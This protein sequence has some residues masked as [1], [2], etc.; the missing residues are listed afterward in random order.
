MPTQQQSKNVDA[1]FM[2]LDRKWVWGIMLCL[3]L[4]GCSTSTVSTTPVTPTSIQ[5]TTAVAQ[6]FHGMV[7]TQDKAFTITL[8]ITPNRPG[9]NVFTAS[10]L[11]N[12]TTQPAS[13]VGITLY[14]TMQ[15]MAMGTDAII[16]HADAN[17]QFSAT[18]S[19]LNMGGH[20]GIAIAVQTSDHIIHKAG[21]NFVAA[22]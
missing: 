10:V 21:L 7:Q 8:D 9:T 4:T 19:N 14:T 12:H 22:F 5:P 13:S 11:D 17:G 16:L 3:L 18:S 20:W 1:W 2:H 6:P 15:D